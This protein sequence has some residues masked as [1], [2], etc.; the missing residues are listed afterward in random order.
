M[1]F[2]DYPTLLWPPPDP[3]KATCA[4]EL[5]Y[6]LLTTPG[7]KIEIDLTHWRKEQP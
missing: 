2:G 7:I 3:S 5:E 1:S 6:L 4:E